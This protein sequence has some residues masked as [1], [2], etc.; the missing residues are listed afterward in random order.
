M[1]RV[2]IVGDRN[3]GKTTFLGLLYAAQV[4]FGSDKADDFR[5]HAAFESLDEITGVFQRLMSGSFPDSVTKEGVREITFRLGHRTPRL[6][7]LSR[8]RL[9]DSA[10]DASAS[11]QFILLK[12]FEDVM[13]RPREGS[14]IAHATLRDAL[15][16]DAIVI[17]VDASKLAGADKDTQLGPMG[18]YDSAVESLLT[19]IKRSR[20]HGG[21]KSLHPV[22]VFTKFDR[23]EPE[24][25]RLANLEAA[26]PGVRRKGPRAAFAKVLL[27][28]S[29]P[30]TM[31]T[32][33]AR[34]RR[35]LRFAMPSYFFSWVRTDEAVSGRAE[36]VRLRPSGAV[37]WE[38][39]YSSDE[40]LAF[41]ECLWDIAADTRD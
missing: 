23:V 11:F 4:K 26:P 1:P 18:K 25:L 5:F 2:A 3:S 14:S 21:G 22:F 33:E 36:K 31:A 8:R 28:R 10:S 12:S 34:G 29:L 16:S 41:L 27:D 17:I 35:G 7:I 32:I 13:A 30:K 15:A 38:P 20:D 39:D 19:S 6:A 40:Y 37:G 24:A 9:R